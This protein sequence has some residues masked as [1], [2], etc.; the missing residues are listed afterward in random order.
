MVE[1]SAR[2]NPFGNGVVFAGRDYA[3]V[4][5]RV[6]V[7]IVD[8][9]VIW[10]LGIVLAVLMPLLW[11]R[12]PSDGE[13]S[14]TW[15]VLVYLYLVPLKISPVR[16]VGYRL[17]GVKI[18]TLKGVRPS[19]IRMTFRL[20]LWWSS[21]INWLSD[22][23]W[24]GGDDCRQTLRDKICGTYVVRKNAF[25][26]DSGPIRLVY[27]FCFS[28]MLTCLEVRRLKAREPAA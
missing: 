6:A 8:A 21:A 14:L 28:L 5:T 11:V 16:T 26:R 13:V 24:M 23:L 7:V 10:P 1:S 22:L 20:L 3:G 25:P 4:P 27:Y 15:L 17:T 18:L 9:A 12:Y 2:Q 19:I